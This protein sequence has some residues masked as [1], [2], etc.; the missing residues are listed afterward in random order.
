[1][2]VIV[3]F[4]LSLCNRDFASVGI[5]GFNALTVNGKHPRSLLFISNWAG[6]MVLL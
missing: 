2:F 6:N 1:M 5:L 4:L 3:V